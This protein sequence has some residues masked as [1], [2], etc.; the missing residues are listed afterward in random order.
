[1][2]IPVAFTG[3]TY[4]VRGNVIPYV[5]GQRLRVRFF[6]KGKLM[7][8]KVVKVAAPSSGT[9]GKFVVSYHSRFP[10]RIVAGITHEATPQQ[11]Y[12][13]A[14]TP[15]VNVIGRTAQQ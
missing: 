15:A 2:S 1:M 10:G 12:A 3:A 6:L 14:A 8:Q 9:V 13:H 5:A 7:A 11:A 4:R